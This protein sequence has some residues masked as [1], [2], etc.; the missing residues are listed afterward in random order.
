MATSG[1]DTK[2]AERTQKAK[3]APAPKEKPA[4]GKTPQFDEAANNMIS[5]GD[6]TGLP[7]D[8]EFNPY[9]EVRP[10]VDPRQPDRSTPERSGTR[11]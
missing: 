1:K 2:P 3:V 5:E 8:N 4:T 7:N 10:R 6:V 9:D 11:N